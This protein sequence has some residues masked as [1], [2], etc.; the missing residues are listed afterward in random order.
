[1][2]NKQRWVNA[3]KCRENDRLIFWPKI[4]GKSYMNAQDFNFKKMSIEDIHNYAGSD[5]LFYLPDYIQIDYGDCGY[6]ERKTGKYFIKEYITPERTMKNVLE[7]DKT[8]LSYHPV[9][10]AI[11]DLEDIK[12]MTRFFNSVKVGIDKQ[13]FDDSIEYYKKCGDK[14]I[15]VDNIAESPLMDFLEWYAGIENGQ[16]LLMDYTDEVETFFNSMQRI[17]VEKAEIKNKA[18]PADVLV[19]TENTSSTLISPAQFRRY[20]KKHLKEYAEISRK[21]EKMLLFH[22]C[23]HLKAFLDDLNEIDFNGIEAFTT[24]PVGNATVKEGKEKLKN[25]CL[26]GCTNCNTWIKKPNEI[27]EEI[28]ESLSELNNYNCIIIGTG[29]VIPPACSPVTL[30]EVC[31]HLFSISFK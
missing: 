8:T 1:M 6:V 24:L 23:G 13:L 27:I 7:F 19:F 15:V 10:M 29:G 4:F 28:E 20:C 26:I 17:N 30:K 9:E 3:L 18:T 14:G 5:I 25:K 12:G 11:K 31:R 21:Y 22:M 2:T 16:Y